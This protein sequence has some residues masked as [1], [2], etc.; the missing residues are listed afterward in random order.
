MAPSTTL[1]PLPP[2]TVGKH[3]VLRSYLGAWLG[4]LG[5]S[6][7]K[8]VLID[9]YA[10]PGEYE[11][12]EWGSP[13]IALDVFENH[14]AR[15]RIIATLMFLFLEEG[16]KRYAHLKSLVAPIAQRLGRRARVDIET[17][18][19]DESMSDLLDQVEA[20]GLELA[21]AFVMVDP[22]G[23]SHLPMALM[24]RILKNP[25][26]EVFISFMFESINRHRGTPEFEPHL[27]ELFG[28]RDWRDMD[29]IADI[30]TRKE[31]VLD[32]YE[33]Q[34]RA[35]GAK[36]VTRFELWDRGRFIYAIY[37]ATS[38][39]LGCDRMKQAIWSADPSGSYQF[40]GGRETQILLFGPDFHIL[41]QELRDTFGGEEVGVDVLDVWVRTDK[42][43]FHS[44]HLRKTLRSM[45]IAGTLSVKD[46]TRTRKKTF[47]EGTRLTIAAR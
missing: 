9:G 43:Q 16:S 36:Y 13:L 35:V 31:F 34:L 44:G 19:F 23:V 12:H 26:A 46:G 39:A 27:D 41:E 1:W 47:P 5:P 17:G 45:E 28:R 4:I 25:R 21:P 2:Q 32:L 29:Q 37:F 7:P 20:A 30:E 3:L 24:A 8:L 40:R 15:D 22:F 11:G 18:R 38:N 6:V 10:G 14:S 33:T 42:T